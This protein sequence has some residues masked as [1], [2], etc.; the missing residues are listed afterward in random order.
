M[1]VKFYKFEGDLVYEVRD[2]GELVFVEDKRFDGTRMVNIQDYTT[3]YI[4]EN[5]IKHIQQ[6]NPNWQQLNCNWDDELVFDTSINQWRVKTPEEL[7][8]DYKQK[9]IEGLKKIAYDYITSNYPLWKQNNDLSD[10]ESIVIKL[11]AKFNGSVTADDIRKSI[12][13]ILAGYSDVYME[14]VK[15]GIKAGFIKTYGV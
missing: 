2:N 6:L 1:K 5:G 15:Y 14:L 9:K 8:N 10:K 11:V 13:N 7:L 12:Y 3:F 4:D